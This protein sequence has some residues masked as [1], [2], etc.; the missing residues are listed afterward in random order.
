MRT[1]DVVS[2]VFAKFAAL[3]AKL[4]GAVA[5]RQQPDFVCA[6]CERWARCGLASSE[7]CVV[8]AA[9]IAR[10]DWTMRRRAK[11]SM[12]MGWPMPLNL[13]RTRSWE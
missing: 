4:A 1:I 9:Q 6:D 7:D 11:F 3:F 2:A 13:L 8:R 5:L 12:V 10:G